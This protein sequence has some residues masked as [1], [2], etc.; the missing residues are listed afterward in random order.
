[1]NDEP[2]LFAG[3]PPL[4]RS[5][6]A[7]REEP[8]EIRAARALCRRMKGTPARDEKRRIATMITGNLVALCKRKARGIR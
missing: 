4:K 1:V 6:P 7:R 2:D 5:T 8:V 3:V